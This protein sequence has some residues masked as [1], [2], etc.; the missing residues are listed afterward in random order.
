MW[1]LP[2]GE[3]SKFLKDYS[4][5]QFIEYILPYRIADEPLEFYWKEDCRKRYIPNSDTDIIAAA[6]SINEQ[7][8][9]ELSPDN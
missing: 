3:E 2:N 8:K 6:K 7:V 4:F 1:L 5:D 9:L